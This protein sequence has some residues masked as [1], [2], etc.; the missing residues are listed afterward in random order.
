MEDPAWR[1][2]LALWPPAS[3]L[4]G[5]LRLQAAWPWPRGAALVKPERLHVTLHFIG[6]VPARRVDDL[7][8]GLQV[9]FTPFVLDTQGARPQV[10]RGG[11]AVLEL[12]SPPALQR[13]HASLASALHALGL[14]VEDRA[15]RPHV[16]FARKAFG[17][18]PPPAVPAIEW[19]AADGY[20]LVRTV[21]GRGY[22]VLHHYR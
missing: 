17:L 11:I 10:W 12:Q 5:L 21:P 8:R 14:P 18:R 2:F 6:P 19:R 20:A 22:E 4:D 1:L 9:P 15:Y 13:L 16:T 3:A 7:R